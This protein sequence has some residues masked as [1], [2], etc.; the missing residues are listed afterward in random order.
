MRSRL[1]ARL[2]AEGKIPA[3]AQPKPQKGKE[4]LYALGRLKT[5]EKN[6]T[7]QRYEDE[8][9]KP[10]MIAG[11]ILWYRFEGIKLRLADNTFLTVDYAVLPADGVLTMVDVKGAAAIVQEDARV[12]MRI[13]A[14]TY[15][16]AFQMAFPNK[17]GG[18]TIKAVT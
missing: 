5:G 4:R 10:G 17:G 6:G 9:L 18:W 14:D 13:A 12:K 2:I 15:P 3:P 16:F 7:E 8:V 1:A 11:E